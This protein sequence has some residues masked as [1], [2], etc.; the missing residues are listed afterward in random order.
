MSDLIE[1]EATEAEAGERLD[2]FL[3]TACPDLSR[4]RVKALISDGAVS[5]DGRVE[6]DP[7]AKARAGAIYRLALP[8]PEP[9]DPQPEAIPLTVLFED[10][11]LLVLD[12]AAGMT[13]HPAAGNWTGTLVNAVL[14]HCAGSL[15]GIGGV[16]RPG[17]VHRLDKD[18]SGVMVVAKSDRAHQ[19]LAAR[20]AEHDV[21][22]A[23]LAVV[24]GGLRPRAG[25]I[26]T[27]L[28]RSGLD[29]KKFTVEADL[30]SE[31]GKLAITHYEVLRPWGQEPEASIGTPLASLVEC[32]LETG[33]THQIRVHMAHMGCP[34]LGDPVYGK[35]KPASL[36]RADASGTVRAFNRQALHAAVLGF[37]H[38]VTGEPLRFE[39]DPPEDMAALIAALDRL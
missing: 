2:R 23:Y 25:T 16:Q 36:M 30:D 9:A 34:L 17:I 21:E 4:T 39:T 10:A 22:R 1:I 32:R 18:T 13:V 29:R 5:V 35:G 37:E 20:F 15:S 12:K 27:R 11:D 6:T 19:G 14:H 24:R 26:E 7:A 33:R 28:V 38:P 8:E 31:A 3:A